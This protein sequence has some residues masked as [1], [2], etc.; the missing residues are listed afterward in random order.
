MAYPGGQP[1]MQQP[2]MGAGLST[3]PYCQELALILLEMSR[4]T[5]QLTF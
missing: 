4:P 1:M 2:G 5:V 3:V